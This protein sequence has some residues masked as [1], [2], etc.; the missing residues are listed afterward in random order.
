MITEIYV[1]RPWFSPCYTRLVR[2]MLA[3]LF[4][5]AAA[6]SETVEQRYID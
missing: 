1:T 6:E 2:H 3:I 5:I 4:S